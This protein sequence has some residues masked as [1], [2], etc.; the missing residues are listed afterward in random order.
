MGD[1]RHWVDKLGCRLAG[2]WENLGKWFYEDSMR[3]FFMRDTDCWVWR[4]LYSNFLPL[5]AKDICA[6]EHHRWMPSACHFR[7]TAD[8]GLLKGHWVGQL[9][10]I[11]SGV[12]E[13]PC[14]FVNACISVQNMHSKTYK[15]HRNSLKSHKRTLNTPLSLR[16]RALSKP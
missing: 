6:L 1:Q 10:H 13:C 16:N 2:L 11:C 8:S 14:A 3:R 5:T 12:W 4:W 9:D 15:M 7:V